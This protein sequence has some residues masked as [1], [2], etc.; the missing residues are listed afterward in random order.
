MQLPGRP[1]GRPS[2]NATCAPSTWRPTELADGLAPQ[3]YLAA[4]PGFAPELG[5]PA[6]P[7]PRTDSAEC[8]GGKL[9]H[10]A[11]RGATALTSFI[12]APMHDP[13]QLARPELPE[14]DAYAARLAPAWDRAYLSSFGDAARELERVCADYTGLPHVRTVAN[15]DLGLTL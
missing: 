9:H 1:C 12:L 11:A 4:L 6:P 5:S 10:G 7:F 14:L 8:E 15:A 2:P 13:I 3:R